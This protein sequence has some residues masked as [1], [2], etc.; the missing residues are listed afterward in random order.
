MPAAHTAVPFGGGLHFVSH[1]PQCTASLSRRRHRLPHLENGGSHFMPHFPSEHVAPPFTGTGQ[2][3][4]QVPQLAMF[5]RK[6]TQ[7]ELQGLVP[8]GQVVTQTPAEH[9]SPGPQRRP[10][11][12]QLEGSV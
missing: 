2:A 3:C 8:V 5:D 4:P 6:S 12:P 11:A 1:A 10:Q 9:T 7:A